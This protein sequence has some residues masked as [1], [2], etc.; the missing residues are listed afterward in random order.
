[1]MNALS[2]LSSLI[3]LRPFYLSI[4]SR[5]ATSRELRMPTLSLLGKMTTIMSLL[6]WYPT[7]MYVL[8]TQC[9]CG[10]AKSTFKNGVQMLTGIT[11]RADFVAAAHDA[12]CQ[13]VQNHANSHYYTTDIISEALQHMTTMLMREHILHGTKRYLHCKCCKPANMKVCMFY[14]HL[15][16]MILNKLQ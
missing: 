13:Q 8:Y 10:V 12:A 4:S 11:C 16:N 2:L 6:E 7:P 3:L 5:Y 14:N 1:M 9:L 15:S